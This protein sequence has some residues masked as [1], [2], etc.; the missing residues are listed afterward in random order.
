[1]FKTILV[2]TDGSALTQAAIN[3]AI[4]FTKGKSDCK[5]IALAVSDPYPFSPLAESAMADSGAY[6]R[7]MQEVGQHHVD[8]IQAAVK[9]ENIPCE[10]IVAQSFS[11]ADE[12]IKAAKKYHCDVIFMGTHG[13]RGIQKL[14]LGSETRKV[15]ARSDIPVLVLR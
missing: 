13:R 14:F 10:G 11:P 1:M 7:R 8:Q 5:I 4:E 15:V 2:P 3:L 9:Q 12:I 6:E